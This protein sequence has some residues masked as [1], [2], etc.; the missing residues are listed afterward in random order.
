MIEDKKDVLLILNLVFLF[1]H[2]SE[3][4]NLV[5]RFL[6]HMLNISPSCG[7]RVFSMATLLAKHLVTTSQDHESA[8]E[9]GQRAVDFLGKLGSILAL[10]LPGALKHT[11]TLQWRELP[12][13]PVAQEIRHVSKCT[14]MQD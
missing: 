12:L 13:I 4:C 1:H 3:N 5:R 6:E 7:R 10:Y 8:K 9:S 11:D 14:L 2:S